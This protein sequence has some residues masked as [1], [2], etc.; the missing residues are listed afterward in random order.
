MRD[1]GR[2]RLVDGAVH[3]CVDE[4]HWDREDDRAVVLR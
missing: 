2:H 4:V 3:G 1:E